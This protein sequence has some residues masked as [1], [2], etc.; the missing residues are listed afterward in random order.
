M[1]TSLSLN[2]PRSSNDAILLL[3][4]LFHPFSLLARDGGTYVMHHAPTA[5]GALSLHR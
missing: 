1:C 5:S 2:A 3:Q 4:R